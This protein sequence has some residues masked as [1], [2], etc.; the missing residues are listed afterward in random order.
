MLARAGRRF[1]GWRPLSDPDKFVAEVDEWIAKLPER[2][3]A[4]FRE[5]AKRVISKMQ[6]R[7]PVDTGFA[8]AS[9]RVSTDAMP[10]L[11]EPHPPHV[12]G[13]EPRSGLLYTYDGNEAT[14]SIANAKLGDTIYAGYTANYVQ[15]L[16]YGHSQQAPQGFVGL[17]AMEWP[18]IVAEVSAQLKDQND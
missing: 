6:E 12:P 9:L 13:R 17:A 10:T 16:E 1:L 5:S 3:E 14:V 8:R 7:V 4:V 15:F 11:S 2:I 18:S